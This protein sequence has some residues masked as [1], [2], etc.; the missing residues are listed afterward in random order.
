MPNRQN[1]GSMKLLFYMG[2]IGLALILMICGFLITIDFDKKQLF[3]NKYKM[4]N[5]NLLGGKFTYIVTYADVLYKI[6]GFMYVLAGLSLLMG[7][8]ICSMF[9]SIATFMY[10]ITIDNPTTHP[11]AQY[12]T[13]FGYVMLHL[14]IPDKLAENI[15]DIID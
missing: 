11:K 3:R 10:V 4:L 5:N 1:Q 14:V 13:K 6:N 8:R 15:W 9:V 7:H 2:R 12:M